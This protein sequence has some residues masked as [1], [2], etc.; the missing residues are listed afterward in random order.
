MLSCSCPAVE[1]SSR[2]DCYLANILLSL[3]PGNLGSDAWRFRSGS[4]IM[5]YQLSFHSVFLCYTSCH[6][7][8]AVIAVLFQVP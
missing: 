1:A 7:I 4:V 2:F 5:D 3:S 6:L 8:S